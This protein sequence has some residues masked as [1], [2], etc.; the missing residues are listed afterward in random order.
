M[1]AWVGQE[2]GGMW[3]AVRGRAEAA[4]GEPPP[5]E[6]GWEQS[7]QWCGKGRRLADL[8]EGR[9]LSESSATPNSY[10]GIESK[11]YINFTARFMVSGR[12]KGPMLLLTLHWH[13]LGWCCKRCWRMMLL[14]RHWQGWCCRRCRRNCGRWRLGFLHGGR[15]LY[16]SA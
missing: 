1:R 4:A 7:V 14:H 9:S 13:W 10:D 11:G 16:V 2:R 3:C 8:E 15:D 6:G 5:Q 12:R